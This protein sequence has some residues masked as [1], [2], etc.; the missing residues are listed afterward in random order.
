ME[1]CSFLTVVSFSSEIKILGRIKNI[2]SS[3][4]TVDSSFIDCQS[5]TKILIEVSS[6]AKLKVGFVDCVEEIGHNDYDVDPSAMLHKSLCSRLRFGITC[7]YPDGI[8]G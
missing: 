8:E 3:K 6:H 7:A 2:Q 4:A 5:Y 1:K